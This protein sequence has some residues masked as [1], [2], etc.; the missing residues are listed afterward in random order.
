MPSPFVFVSE[1]Q[2]E[3]KMQEQT[4]KLFTTKDTSEKRVADH[5]QR[6]IDDGNTTLEE[7]IIQCAKTITECFAYIKFEAKKQASNGC[8]M[9]DDDVVYG[10]AVHYYEELGKPKG[11]K[12]PKTANASPKDA[13]AKS[14]SATSQTEIKQAKPAEVKNEQLTFDLF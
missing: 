6:I 13:T 12:Q 11:Y 10:W 3:N 9:I 2:E 1:K 7:K 5:L 8:A 4:I 14:S